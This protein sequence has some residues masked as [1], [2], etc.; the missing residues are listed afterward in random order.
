MTKL[1]FIPNILFRNKHLQTI[2]SSNA[3]PPVGDMLGSAQ[4]M[5]L[6][7]SIPSSVNGTETVTLNAYY[8]PQINRTAKGIVILFHGW[9]GSSSST[10]VLARGESL[11]REGYA[12]VRLNLRDHG[13]TLHLNKGVFHGCRLEEVYQ[14]VRHIALLNP[15]LP[16]TLIGFS[17]GGSFALRTAWRDSIDDKSLDNLKKVIAICPSV[18]PKGVGAVIDSSFIYRRYFIANLRHNLREKQNYFPDIYNFDDLIGLNTCTAITE[19]LLLKYTDYSD[20]D[21]YYAEYRF[22]KEKLSDIS[23]P[24]EIIAAKDDPVIPVDHFTELENVN[25]KCNFHITQYGGHVGYISALPRNS[26]L[27]KILPNLI[28]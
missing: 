12:V 5:Q 6:N 20:C 7:L 27:D 19:R 10:Y 3:K 1:H 14:A 9:L 2:L 24:V 25:P 17:M 18:N 23:I 21:S 8:S 4:L 22:T 16:I 26:W 15:D 13:D 11:Y 28:N